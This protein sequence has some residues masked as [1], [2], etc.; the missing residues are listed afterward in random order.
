ME[1]PKALIVLLIRVYIRTAVLFQKGM[2]QL[3]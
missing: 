1:S 2:M 3:R